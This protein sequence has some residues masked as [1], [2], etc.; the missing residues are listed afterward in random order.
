MRDDPTR[1]RP[2]TDE[3]DDPQK[4]RR[5]RT[6]IKKFFVTLLIFCVAGY[7][8]FGLA[9]GIIPGKVDLSNPQNLF[10]LVVGAAAAIKWHFIGPPQFKWRRD[11][12]APRKSTA[13]W[14]GQAKSDGWHMTEEAIPE[15]PDDGITDR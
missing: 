12:V 8:A 14:L 3:P 7:L 5:G 2:T 4:P 1:G 11:R 9:R 6:S 10:G 15:C 13:A